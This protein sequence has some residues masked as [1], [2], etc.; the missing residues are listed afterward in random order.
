[1]ITTRKEIY[2]T[3]KFRTTMTGYKVHGVS[4]EESY[5]IIEA[6]NITGIKA[7]GEIRVFKK[8]RINKQKGGGK[9]G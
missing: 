8:E 7:D 5:K 3:K 1:M 4:P 9:H 2:E 6:Q